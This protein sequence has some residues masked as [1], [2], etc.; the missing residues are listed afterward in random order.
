LGTASGQKIGFFLSRIF[1][2]KKFWQ[3][4]RYQKFRLV[5]KNALI[6]IWIQSYSRELQRRCCKNLRH[7]EWPLAIWGKYFFFYFEKML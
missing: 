1:E 5:A 6:L 2:T 7:Y 3:K 4:K